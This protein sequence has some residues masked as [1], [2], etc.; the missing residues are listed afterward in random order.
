MTS[1]IAETQIEVLSNGTVTPKNGTN[2]RQPYQH[3]KNAM[4]N[5]DLM[6][7]EDAYSTLV[8][9]PTGGGKTYT[10]SLW[11][12]KHALDRH[13]KILWIAHRQMLLDQAAESFQKY[14]YAESLPSITSFRYRII[15]GAPSHDR[16][17]DIVPTDDLVI[18]SKDS[19]GRNLSA[20][21]AW[22]AGTD[23]VYLV[24]DEAHHATAKTYRKIIDYVEAHVKRTKLIGL[25]ATPFRTAE[26]ERGLLA[27]IFHDGVRNGRRVKGD[28]GITYQIGLKDL[29]NRQ[30]LSQPI[31]ESCYTEEDY[32]TALGKDDWERIMQLDTLPDDLA[33]QIADSAPRNRLIVETYKK[34]ADVYGQTL[35]FAVNVVHAITLAKIFNRAGVPADFVVSDVKDMVTGVRISRAD[36]ERKLQSYRDGKLKVLVNVNILTEGVDLPQTKTVFLARPTVS[37]ILMTQMIGRALRGTAAGGTSEAYI[38]SFVDDWNEH[39]AW[40]NPESIFTGDGNDFVENAIARQQHELRMIAISKIEEF[41]SIVDGS[42]D[43]T[44]LE[45]VPFEKRI[46]LG[47]YAF[48]WLEENGMDHSYQ[49][50]VYDSTQAAYAEMMDALPKLFES[51]G[52]DDEYLSD[53]TLHEM[54]EQCRDTFFLG[55]MIPSYDEQDIIHVLQYYAQ[56][57]SAPNFYTFDD[58]DRSK[59]D[60]AA[61]AKH[62]FD[63][64]MGA[65]KKAEYVNDL[66]N[67]SDDNMLRLFF[68]RKQYFWKQLDIE[69]M[70]LSDIGIYGDEKNVQYGKK[71]LA[72]MP[73]GEIARYNPAFEKELRDGAFAAAKD[74]EGYYVCASCGKR[75]KSRIPFQVEHIVPMNRGG[76]SI[77]EN[78]QILCRACNGRKSDR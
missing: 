62:I 65:R 11:L 73:L 5:L 68:G 49:V 6:D 2:V 74:E 20:L 34:K 41:A 22:L 26:Q 63:E 78:L 27:K 46:P 18:A 29:I 71:K 40:V 36:N 14:A 4:A 67:R 7:A 77:P 55:D 61:I 43:T 44:A 76:K 37:T 19:I 64:D 54:A 12:L 72:D 57:E 9:L 70:K 24:I 17:I 3:Q 47:M 23:E 69:I 42:I 25:T 58:I 32:G 60:V 35:V 13:K 51:F 8:V 1:K 16:S 30:I 45:A 39:I 75:D 15:S 48:T 50:M 56:K 28:V 38:V 66:W 59:L 21:D 10:A 53:A 52:C 31:F 33:T